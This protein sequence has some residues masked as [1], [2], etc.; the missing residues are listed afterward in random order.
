MLTFQDLTWLKYIFKLIITCLHPF[1]QYPRGGGT[2]EAWPSRVQ[3]SLV[4][5]LVTSALVRPTC[6]PAGPWLRGHGLATTFPFLLLQQPVYRMHMI[7]SAKWLIE[8]VGRTSLSLSHWMLLGGVSRFG[9]GADD[10]PAGCPTL[11]SALARSGSD[12]NGSC[13]RSSHQV[14]PCRRDEAHRAAPVILL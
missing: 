8:V 2:R 1:C 3:T 10:G 5:P 14:S 9:G 6:L 12:S 11:T 13:A 7:S 4:L